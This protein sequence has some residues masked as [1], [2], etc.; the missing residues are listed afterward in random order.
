MNSR[1]MTSWRIVLKIAL[2]WKTALAGMRGGL[3]IFASRLCRRALQ[4]IR[5]CGKL[6]LYPKTP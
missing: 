5:L 2:L 1:K 3:E 4:K 6:W